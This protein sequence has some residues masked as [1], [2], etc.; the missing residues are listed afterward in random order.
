MAA[1]ELL[2]EARQGLDEGRPEVFQKASE[3]FELFQRGQ[4]DAR[5]NDALRV[6]ISFQHHQAAVKERRKPVEALQLVEEHLASAR[7]SGNRAR[8]ACVLLS[9]AEINMDRRGQ[10]KRQEALEVC[11]QALRIFQELQDP[12]EALAQLILTNLYFKLERPDKAQ[13]AAAMAVELAGLTAEPVLRAKALHAGALA[14]AA[15]HRYADAAQQALEARGIFHEEGNVKMEAAQL[16]SVAQW[17]LKASKPF[18]ALSAAEEA[19]KIFRGLRYGKGWQ[20]R[21]LGFLCEA[22]VELKQA[23]KAA[24]L[25]KELEAEFQQA[26][27]WSSAAEAA[28][29]QSYAWANTEKP[30]RA[31]EP[32][33]A[34]REAAQDQKGWAVRILQGQAVAFLHAGEHGEALRKLR[35]ACAAAHAEGDV[36]QELTTLR[37]IFRVTFDRGDFEA[38]LQAAEDSWQICHAAGDSKGEVRSA[39]RWAA[40]AANA[41]TLAEAVAKVKDAQETSVASEDRVGEAQA[42]KLLSELRKLEGDLDAALQA[43]EECLSLVRAWGIF[44]GRRSSCTSW[45]S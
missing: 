14:L 31:M 1:S 39:L 44:C 5:A 4:D 3:A 26:G 45:P 8:E 20:V 29:L 23:P 12:H 36:R 32:L 42:L 33:E 19:L 27:D 2:E 43:A 21:A 10:K 34:A 17:S 37:Q 16:V 9:L 18:Q 28:E 13:Q 41:R 11:L 30:E 24:K 7:A 25:A 35:R 22:L 38:A 40:A 15:Q 6:M